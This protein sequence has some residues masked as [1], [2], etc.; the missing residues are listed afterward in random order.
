MSAIQ[1]G[2][3]FSD[4]PNQVELQLLSPFLEIVTLNDVAHFKFG[5]V[6][7]FDATF[8]THSHFFHVIL[9]SAQR[10]YSSI[11]N[12]LSATQN[13][14]ATC[15]NNPPVGHEAAGDSTLGEVKNLSDFCMPD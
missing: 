10:R 15:A 7:K 3:A 13:P 14:G 8:D 2:T 5:K 11:V 1:S 9:E 12:R 6:A 4:R